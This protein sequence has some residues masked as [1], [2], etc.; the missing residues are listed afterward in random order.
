MRLSC[1]FLL[2][3]RL[4][5]LLL[6]VLGCPRWMRLS[7]R[8]LL[9]VRLLLLLVACFSWHP[10]CRL[11]PWT[12]G[13]GA[14]TRTR[15]RR[16]VRARF[17]LC[18]SR[19]RSGSNRYW[20]ACCYGLGCGFPGRLGDLLEGGGVRQQRDPSTQRRV[21]WPLPP[22][23]SH[24]GPRQPFHGQHHLSIPLLALR[25]A[26]S[27]SRLAHPRR[28]TQDVG[29]IPLTDSQPYSSLP[30]HVGLVFGALEENALLPERQQLAAV[31]SAKHHLK[32]GRPPGA[33]G[34]PVV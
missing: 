33:S 30:L 27:A 8:F 1:R 6:L 18:S 3:V 29:A 7:C 9:C 23:G 31:A 17:A 15:R 21:Q 19:L 14:R 25:Q 28:C 13:A 4:L 20:S 22:R 24:V 2:C 10:A 5:L 16:R 26:P 34:K 12:S 11:G 32:G